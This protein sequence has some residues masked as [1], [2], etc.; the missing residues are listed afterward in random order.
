MS[1]KKQPSSSAA[2]ILTRIDSRIAVR[3][4]NGSN[5]SDRSISLEAT[6]SADTIRSIR[7]GVADG[8]QN[9]ISTETL[10][11]LAGPLGTTSDWLLTGRGIEDIDELPI[12]LW[13]P[14]IESSD[15]L[16]D[17]PSNAHRTVKL[18][19]YVGAGSEAHLY[20][21]SDDFFEEV[22]AMP[23]ASDQ[24]VAVEIKGRSFGPLMDGWLVHYEDVRS[25]FTD[26]MLNKICVVGLADDRILLKKVRRENDGSFTLISNSADEPLIRDANIEWAA[27]VVGF[28]PRK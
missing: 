13:P 28:A 6:G 4:A 8:T 10:R 3:K 9:G 15:V 18:K 1:S 14:H 23:G 7:R 26:D 5:F 16:P 17:G 22:E 24:S 19:G 25:P 21:Y 27:L 11:K 2:D 12:S 20:A